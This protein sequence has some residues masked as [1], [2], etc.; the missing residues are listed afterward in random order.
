MENTGFLFSEQRLSK[1]SEIC[2]REN[3]GTRTAIRDRA[4]ERGYGFV[5]REREKH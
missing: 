1:K 3:M 5:L 2:Q 4:D